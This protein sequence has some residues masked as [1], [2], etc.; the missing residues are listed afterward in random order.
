M[1]KALP[2][3][4]IGSQEVAMMNLQLPIM[5]M[6][7]RNPSTDKFEAIKFITVSLDTTR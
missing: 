7:I 2:Q 4:D 5:E 3:R 1:I 6:K